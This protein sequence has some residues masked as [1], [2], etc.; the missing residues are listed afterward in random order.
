MGPAEIIIH[1]EMGTQILYAES[2]QNP[3]LD[4]PPGGCQSDQP[5]III[6]PCWNTKSTLK[7]PLMKKPGPPRESRQATITES[8]KV[9]FP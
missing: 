3:K 4:G 5:F 9:R 8:G 1:L 6:I 2:Y 7:E